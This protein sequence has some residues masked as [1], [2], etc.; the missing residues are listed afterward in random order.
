MPITSKNLKIMERDLDDSLLNIIY[1]NVNVFSSLTEQNKFIKNINDSIA[2]LRNNKQNKSDMNVY[3][4][5]SEI[6]KETELEN[7]L[8]T[9]INA[10]ITE[11]RLHDNLKSRINN[12]SSTANTALSNGNTALTK[13]T[14]IEGKYT[15]FQN[16]VDTTM[17]AYGDRVSAMELTVSNLSTKINSGSGSSSGSTLSSD[18]IN[19]VSNLKVDM[20]DVQNRVSTLENSP[21]SATPTNIHM[22][23]LDSD[24]Q[25]KI[26]E[27]SSKAT[28]EGK[29][30]VR[31][32]LD[33]C[34]SV[35]AGEETDENGL[36]NTGVLHAAFL[37]IPGR[38]AHN[39]TEASSIAAT[40]PDILICPYQ[41]GTYAD[42][43]AFN[44]NSFLIYPDLEK[45]FDSTNLTLGGKTFKKISQAFSR[46]WFGKH[47]FL[48]DSSTEEILYSFGTQYVTIENKQNL[49][50]L[51]NKVNS[52][53]SNGFTVT[54]V[55]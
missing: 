25:L 9:K 22:N 38:I 3:R 10:K 20:K 2:E 37:M 18:I 29:A 30:I 4:L 54:F 55:E 36:K 41:S 8:Q 23:Q 42:M 12:I 26:T 17:S 34:I 50:A 24:L 53:Q 21:A 43:I 52:L 48:C 47:K 35:L 46:H 16:K 13:C 27:A 7:A 28:V 14:D 49:T 44:P 6:V 19:S 32:G 31:D 1:G 51:T 15:S 40:N 45:Q 11:D 33:A 39:D 5:K